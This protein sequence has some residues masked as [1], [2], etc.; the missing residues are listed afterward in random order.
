ERLTRLLGGAV[1]VWGAPG[2]RRRM[3]LFGFRPAVE[4]GVLKR[5]WHDLKVRAYPD[6]LVV[7]QEEGSTLTFDIA[8]GVVRLDGEPFRPT[9]TGLAIAEALVGL[10]EGYE[11][12][13]E[14]RE[15]RVERLRR[16]RPGAS[17]PR[18]VNALAETRRIRRILTETRRGGR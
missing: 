8:D 3:R 5:E 7:A 13:V 2:E 9:P 10:I 4:E 16:A 14:A 6:R 15:G 11:R 12:W 18:P 17:D 1:D